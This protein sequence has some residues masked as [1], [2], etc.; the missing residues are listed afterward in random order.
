MLYSLR[1]EAAS[2]AY[3]GPCFVVR[4]L[5]IEGL[6]FRGPGRSKEQ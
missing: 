2:V 3:S 1:Q 6:G 5:P 4:A